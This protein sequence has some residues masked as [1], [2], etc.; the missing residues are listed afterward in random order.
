MA[1]EIFIDPVLLA[2]SPVPGAATGKMITA[3]DPDSI[4]L[5]QH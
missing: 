5:D 1:L 2:R 4:D 3:G